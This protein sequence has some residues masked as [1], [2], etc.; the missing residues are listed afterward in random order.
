MS[1][2]WETVDVPRGSF[3]SWGS[4]PGQYVKGQVVEYQPAGGSDFNG[5][6]CPQL[7]LELTEPTV[8]VNKEGVT[9]NIAAGELVVLNCGLKNL[10]KAVQAAQL[11]PGML[12]HITFA[13]TLKVDKGT[14]KVFEIRKAPRALQT[15]SPGQ[16]APPAADPWGASQQGQPPF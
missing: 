11:E 7:T 8:S 1:E 10:K 5:Q 13:S 12:A 16:A 2:Q 14:V 3:I 6:D 9:T 15:T 4:Q